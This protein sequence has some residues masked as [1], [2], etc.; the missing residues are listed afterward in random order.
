M[1]ESRARARPPHA[2]QRAARGR[3]ETVAA[4]AAPSLPLQQPLPSAASGAARTGP[5][6]VTRRPVTG[7]RRCSALAAW[8]L[9]D[10]AATPGPPCWSLGSQS[11]E[12]E[13]EGPSSGEG[14]KGKRR[15]WGKERGEAMGGTWS[16]APHRGSWLRRSRDV[17]Q[18]LSKGVGDWLPWETSGDAPGRLRPLP[19]RGETLAAAARANQRGG[20][21]M[22]W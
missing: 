2:A 19:W 16:P 20:C 15:S 6:C 10:A 22:A 1:S 13:R 21:G 7:S 8:A 14:E 18:G 12:T 17:T 11:F 5:D 4:A 3:H 9:A